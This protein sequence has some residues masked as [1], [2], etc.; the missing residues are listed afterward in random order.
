VT[1]ID[2]VSRGK[3]RVEPDRL[4]D[5][6]LHAMLERYRAAL[7][8]ALGSA[9]RT[10]DWSPSLALEMM[11]RQGIEAAI[12]SLTAPGVHF[13]C[14]AQAQELAQACND[15]MAGILAKHPRFGAFA[16]L[17]L[18]NV[19]LACEEARR[20]LDVLK[21]DGVGILTGYHGRYL[22]NSEFDPLFQ[23]LDQRSAVVFIH[24]AAHPSIETITLGVPNFMLEY[25]FDTTRAAVSLLFADVLDRFPNIRFILSHGGGVLPYIS[26]RIATIAMRQLSQPPAHEKHLRDLYPTALTRRHEI[27]TADLVKDLLR[28]FWYDVALTADASGLGSLISFADPA[29]ILFGS[30]WPY[31]YEVVVADQRQSIA[32]EAIVPAADRARLSRQNAASL[33]PRFSSDKPQAPLSRFGEL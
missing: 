17:P 26:W 31:A 11:D 3:G 12:L 2:N 14:D 15:E 22:G 8:N 6:H 20:A 19:A 18:P 5:V 33:F 24:P 32:N 7:R 28:R 13:G 23:V 30:D 29:R 21:L 1:T 4:I 9:A 27:V 25:P 10:P 16:T